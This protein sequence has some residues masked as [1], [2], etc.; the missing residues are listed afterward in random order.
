MKKHQNSS[1]S[2]NSDSD[3]ERHSKRH[4]SSK[5]KKE[6]KE[7]KEKKDK[8]E[9]KSDRVKKE[10]DT[11][12]KMLKRKGNPI[13]TSDDYFSKSSEFILWLKEA[14]NIIF[15][16]L[17]SVESKKLFEKFIRRYNDGVLIAK[18]YDGISSTEISSSD[19]SAYK[20]K[21]NM[22]RTK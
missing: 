7:K 14:K 5:S 11:H 22:V 1:S 2:S 8:K 19:R 6:K 9:K 4:K 3:L 10:E 12:E 18:Y 13:I 15:N 20:W 17:N 21:L 16:D